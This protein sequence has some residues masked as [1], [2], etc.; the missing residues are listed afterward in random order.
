[1]TPSTLT[2]EQLETLKK[3]LFKDRDTILKTIDVL[4]AQD[5]FNDPEHANDNAA[6]DSDV[7]DQMG[8]DTVEAEIKSLKRKLR[9]VE[10]ALRKMEN[11][12]YGVD[13]KSGSQIPFERLRIVPEAQYTVEVEKKLVK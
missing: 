6:F 1:M 10:K 13:E 7:R 12:T 8:H 5:P 11:G 9:L 2:Q 4:K 3:K